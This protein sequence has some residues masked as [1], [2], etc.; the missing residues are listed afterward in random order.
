M[1]EI[2]KSKMVDVHFRVP[3]RYLMQFLQCAE[4]FPGAQ[5]IRDNVTQLLNP[6]TPIVAEDSLDYIKSLTEVLPFGKPE[7]LEQNES[8]DV[9]KPLPFRARTLPPESPN[10]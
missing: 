6:G 9:Q 10:Q 7:T 1:S 5:L 2:D 3:E 8:E 4:E